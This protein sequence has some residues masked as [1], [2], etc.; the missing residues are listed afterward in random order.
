[1]KPLRL[2]PVLFL[3]ILLLSLALLSGNSS[4]TRA[5]ADLFVYLPIVHGGS[6]ALDLSDLMVREVEQVLAELDNGLEATAVSFNTYALTI[7]FTAP[8]DAQLLDSYDFQETLAAINNAI[9]HLLDEQGY[10]EPHNFNYELFVNGQPLSPGMDSGAAAVLTNGVTGV[11]DK[12]IAISPGHGWR[13]SG[14]GWSLDRGYH[15]GIVED[16]INAELV[17]ALYPQL[18]ASGA[19]VRP[20]RQM[21]KNVGNHASG[22]PWWEMGSSEYVRNLGAPPSVWGSSFSGSNRNIVAP[23]EYAN[24]VNADMLVSV[25]NNGA[26]GC[27][28]ET[29]YDTSNGYQEESHR[30][31][32]LIQTKLVERLRTQWDANWCDRGVKGSAGG[33]GENRRFHGP[34]VIVEL[35]F[36]DN[37]AN[38]SALQNATFRAIAM[39]AVHD[40]IVEYY[41][42]SPTPPPPASTFSGGPSS[43]LFIDQNGE[44]INLEVCA[45]NVPGQTVY[46]RLSR[47]GSLFN[48]VSQVANGRCVTFWNLD[49]D[50]SLLDNTP[51]TTRA[52][53]NQ[54]PNDSWS[55]PCFHATGG[56]G[57]CDTVSTGS[58]VT[59]VFINGHSTP[60]INTNAINLEVCADNLAGKI[61]YAQMWRAAA[62]GYPAR[63]W[64]YS[65]FAPGNCVTFGDMDG[66]GDT[67]ANVDYYT[68]AAIEPIDSNEAAQQRTACY[69]ATGYS[70]LCDRVRRDT[71]SNIF[72]NGVSTPGI[73]TNAVNLQVCAD[74]LAG[75]TVY[76][77]MWRAAANGYPAHTWNYSQ[78]APG[79]CVTFS[80]M[81]GAGGTFAGVHYYTVAAIEPIG[82]DEAAQQRTAC[83]A[84]TGHTRLCDRVSR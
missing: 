58:Q 62:Q 63:T 17:M 25:H 3:L 73:N 39:T 45:D 47:P 14:S 56:R 2:K 26:G 5:T 41:E 70:R 51:Y 72:I 66:A 48:V 69:E 60:A 13:V 49:G 10:P 16:F 83:Y 6:A 37:Q 80:D 68:V 40:A 7:H 36:M 22:H 19:D 34:A 23:P 38:N 61:V 57:L 53:L 82:S 29:W 81:D 31:A 8:A 32:Q 33:Y 30:L 24:W 15:W 67:F 18:L 9:N 4:I 84:A 42:G 75:K 35:A 44:R 1:M 55:V 52:A 64:N 78:F 59:N 76:A 54:P 11:Q 79:N 77:Q 71:A 21:D 43:R 74:N 65:Q 27:G 12:R 20:V 28:T 50:G 46:A